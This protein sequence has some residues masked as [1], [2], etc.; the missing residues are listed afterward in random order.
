MSP[1]LFIQILG[2]TG[3]VLFLLAYALVS[4]KKADG[5]S[6]LY[7]GMNIVAG[8]FLVIYTFTLG[9]YATTGLNAVWVAIGLFTLG[10]KWLNRR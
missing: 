5:D 1:H 6:L 8:A 7:Q 4:L 2:W 9:A 10:R 3:S